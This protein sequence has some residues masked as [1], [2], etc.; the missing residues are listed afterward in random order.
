[1][2]Y[3]VNKF[4]SGLSLD[5]NL[6]FNLCLSYYF[7]SMTPYFLKLF[8]LSIPLNCYVLDVAHFDS[9]SALKLITTYSGIL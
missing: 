6:S 2:A 9:T 8:L 4:I 5:L 1:M 7:Y 3:E